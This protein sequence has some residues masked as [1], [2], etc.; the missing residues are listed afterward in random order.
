MTVALVRRILLI[1]TSGNIVPSPITASIQLRVLNPF[2]MFGKDNE[3]D[4]SRRKLFTGKISGLYAIAPTDKA[5]LTFITSGVD[6]FEDKDITLENAQT[7]TLNQCGVCHTADGAAN[8]LSFSRD[9]FPL[10]SNNLPQLT[11]TSVSIET[12]LIV[13]WKQSQPNWHLLTQYWGGT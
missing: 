3:F 5:L 6:Y 4:L 11:E 8:I 12:N 13:A 10:P 1:D 9:R 7:V 2:A